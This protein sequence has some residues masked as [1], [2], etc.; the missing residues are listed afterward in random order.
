M[1]MFDVRPGRPGFRRYGPG[2]VMS[3]GFNNAGSILRGQYDWEGFVKTP[4]GLAWNHGSAIVRPN[5][6]RINPLSHSIPY[7]LGVRSSIVDLRTDVAYKFLCS[8]CSAIRGECHEHEEERV[9]MEI[10]YWVLEL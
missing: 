10:I 5:S 8:A 9:D 6:K 2:C 4:T 7:G 1:N 3:I